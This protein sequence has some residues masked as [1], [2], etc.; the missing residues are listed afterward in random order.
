M[1]NLHGKVANTGRSGYEV[2]R[3][4]EGTDARPTA[5]YCSTV[6]VLR[7]PSLSSRLVVSSQQRTC[8]QQ[9]TRFRMLFVRTCQRM[10]T[11][12]AS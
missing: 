10:R 9:G 12:K 7:L 8:S 11:L 2:L 5:F 4:Q 1:R 6:L 3:N